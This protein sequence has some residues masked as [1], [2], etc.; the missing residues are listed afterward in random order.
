MPHV[1]LPQAEFKVG[2]ASLHRVDRSILER[3]ER[4]KGNGSPPLSHLAALFCSTESYVESTVSHWHYKKARFPD[5]HTFASHFLV[6]ITA[7]YCIRL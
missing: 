4:A 7:H 5:A 2:K 1:E 3:I 6:L